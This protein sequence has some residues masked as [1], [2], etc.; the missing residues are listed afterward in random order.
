M[1][2]RA[3]LGLCLYAKCAPV[4]ATHLVYF[5]RPCGCYNENVNKPSAMCALH[6]DMFLH[7]ARK[8]QTPA[9][10]CPKC[11]QRNRVVAVRKE[12]IG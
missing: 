5:E 1:G 7:P 3:R 11:H 10:V 12:K 4:M 2:I 8:A 9:T 6:A